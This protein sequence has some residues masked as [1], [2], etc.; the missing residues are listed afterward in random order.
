MM[1]LL[2]DRS[3]EVSDRRLCRESH[4]P[5]N[6]RC[7]GVGIPMIAFL[8]VLALISLLRAKYPIGGGRDVRRWLGSSV[9]GARLR[10]KAS[11][12]LQR[13]AVFRSVGLRWW[14][15]S[16]RKSHSP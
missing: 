6:R 4:N 8:L 13:L 10:A 1:A 15:I 3:W 5:V 9:R 12:V 2:S 14:L 7:H 11:R 16:L